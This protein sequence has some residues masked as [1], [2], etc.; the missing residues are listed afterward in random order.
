MRDRKGE[1]EKERESACACGAGVCGGGRCGVREMVEW[2]YV[3][4]V[5]LE[6]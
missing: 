3:L 5:V 6:G 1:R 4:L 2:Q